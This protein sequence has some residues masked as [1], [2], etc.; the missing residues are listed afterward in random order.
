MSEAVAGTGS[1][2]GA[3][4]A[5]WDRFRD[6][7]LRRVTL[8]D[9]AAVALLTGELDSEQRLAAL[10]EA[11]KLAGSVGTFGFAE[12]SRLARSIELLLEGT[13]PLT[14]ADSLRLADWVVALRIHLEGPASVLATAGTESPRLL[15]VTAEHDLAERL[16]MEAAGRGF[17]IE[18]HADSATAAQAIA[19][20]RFS[21]AVLDV[22]A[23]PA[24][25]DALMLLDALAA[26]SPPP[27][28]VVIGV[29][30][31]FRERIDAVRRGGDVFLKKPVAAALLMDAVERS[32]RRGVAAG[33]QVLVLDDDRETLERLE[34]VLTR[35]GM[36]V[37]G[38]VDAAGFWSALGLA[39]DVVILGL[40]TPGLD[41]MDLCRALRSHP[42]WTTLPVL[43][44][45]RRS[46]PASIQT[47][48]SAGA[49]DYVMKPVVGP[50]LVARLEN[51][52]AR[53]RLHSAEHAAR[54]PA[55]LHGRQHTSEEITRLLHLAAR[56]GVHLAVTRIDVD[57]LG[58]VNTQLGSVAGDAVLER[59]ALL[60][61]TRAAPGDVV[62]WWGGDEF[63][64]AFFDTDDSGAA[65]W[66]ETVLDSAGRE[67]VPTSAGD[68]R[69]TFSAGLASC[70]TDGSELGALIDAAERALAVAKKGGGAQVV[71]HGSHR[72]ST[73]TR[74]V[75]IALIEDDPVLSDLLCHALTMQGYATHHFVDGESAVEQLAGRSPAMR[76]RLILLDIDLPGRDGFSVLRD[77]ARDGV[78]KH[79]YV[80]MLTA[81]SS[82][83][84][85]LAA[86]EMGAT[87]HVAKPF[88][89]PVLLQ[90]IRALLHRR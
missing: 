11:H 63:A 2:E 45:T 7:V 16:T 67:P 41:A 15:L 48:F 39:P 32:V 56:A 51:R 24:G 57:G 80:V 50:E 37:H 36:K 77:I 4:A 81:R 65:R 88:S 66:L 9:N 87:E 40:E 53:A 76:A 64:V 12:A 19:A 69:V 21:A 72:A 22:D 13:E 61:Q 70:P 71:L 29:H 85:I 38:V 59:L 62:G 5:L 54:G 46:D 6:G 86:L 31:G 35:R 17:V 10:R 33:A 47:I 89:L 34:R 83:R 73:P 84:E 27:A 78:L 60:M 68:L 82:E 14:E 18:E 1:L 75:D 55:G 8:L 90:R 79:T 20:R 43:L 49:D 42:R 25:T 44:L 26:Q 23:A 74:Q 3:V 52:L 28:A 30:D 58:R